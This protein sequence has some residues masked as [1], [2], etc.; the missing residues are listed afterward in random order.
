MIDLDAPIVPGKSAVG[1]LV[2]SVVGEL[3]A[4]VHSTTKLSSG[5]SMILGRSRSGPKT[6]SLTKSASILDTVVCYS[7]ASE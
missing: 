5:R 1:V 6:A 3:L 4:T 7:Q 2:G